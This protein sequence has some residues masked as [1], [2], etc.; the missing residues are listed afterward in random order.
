MY[1]YRNFHFINI[2]SQVKRRLTDY[3]SHYASRCQS[4]LPFSQVT[5]LWAVTTS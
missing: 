5:P 3:Q 2:K 4:N 1:I